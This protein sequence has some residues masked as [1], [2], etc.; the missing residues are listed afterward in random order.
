MVDTGPR[1]TGAQSLFQKWVLLLKKLSRC[2]V[3]R[4]LAVFV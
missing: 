2:L 1:E 4:D 3:L